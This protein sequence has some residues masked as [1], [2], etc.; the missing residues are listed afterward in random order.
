MLTR[1]EFQTTVGILSEKI[2]ADP[3]DQTMIGQLIAHYND[4]EQ[5]FFNQKKD[6]EKQIAEVTAE[7]DK[8][9][10]ERDEARRAY[11]NNFKTPEREKE[12]KKEKEKEYTPPSIDMVLGR[13]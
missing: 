3:R 4:T 7:R 2:G 10:G 13:K 8:A 5:Q 1:D 6:F 12:K 11:A 9:I